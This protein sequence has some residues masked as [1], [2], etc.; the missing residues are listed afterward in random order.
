MS[1]TT[2]WLILSI[3]AQIVLP[4]LNPRGYQRGKLFTMPL[5]RHVKFFDNAYCRL[6]QIFALWPI[7]TIVRHIWT[8]HDTTISILWSIA[9]IA[10]YFDD[11][12][13]NHDDFQKKWDLVRNKIKWKMELPEPAP[14]GS[15]V[16]S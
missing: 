5:R 16:G 8:G 9:V 7:D 14:A 1:P 15:K 13:T 2:T 3:G 12:M 10:L 4:I 11:W 6:M